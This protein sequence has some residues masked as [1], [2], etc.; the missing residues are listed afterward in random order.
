MYK[1]TT[2]KC[3]QCGI[4]FQ[5][6]KPKQK[7]CSREC[8]NKA[9]SGEKHHN[10]TEYVELEC[11]WCGK[12]Y[13]VIP[14]RAENSLYCSKECRVAATAKLNTG[15]K[16]EKEHLTYRCRWCRKLFTSSRHSEFCSQKCKND[17]KNFLLEHN[18]EEFYPQHE[19]DET[20]K[21]CPICGKTFIGQLDFCDVI[22][23]ANSYI[24]N[25]EL[26]NKNLN[27]IN[28]YLEKRVLK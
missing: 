4:E 25:K 20:E 2:K 16:I 27:K 28:Y 12:K 8:A 6:R 7:Y 24:I 13:S 14:S 9:R 5:T 3:M 19:A 17:A 11:A 18:Y 15:R 21:T 26:Y 22:C 1:L 23:H 10:H